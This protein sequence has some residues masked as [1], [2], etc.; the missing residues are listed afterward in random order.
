MNS[1]II[2]RPSTSYLYYDVRQIGL[3]TR[4]TAPA[5]AFGVG[6][7][8][9]PVVLGNADDQP[10][11]R[12]GLRSGEPLFFIARRLQAANHGL[13]S[14]EALVDCARRRSNRARQL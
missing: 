8:H 4:V 3:T 12:R 11:L 1:A 13:E 6:Y 2:L 14:N 10:E 5:L 7:R 9:F